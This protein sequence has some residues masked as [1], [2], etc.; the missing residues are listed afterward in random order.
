MWFLTCFRLDILVRALVHILGLHIVCLGCPISSLPINRLRQLSTPAHAYA[1]L[2]LPPA[3]RSNA[4]IPNTE[5]KHIC[6]CCGTL[7]APWHECL[8][9]PQTAATHSPPFSRH[10]RQSARSPTILGG[11]LPGKIGNANTNLTTSVVRFLLYLPKG[12][13]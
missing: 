13:S 8:R 1:P 10:R 2:Y 12:H 6:P 5:V 9:C 11:R 3:A 7:C 4:A